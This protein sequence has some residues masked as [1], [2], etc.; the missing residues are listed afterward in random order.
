MDVP[1]CFLLILYIQ[2]VSISSISI[3]TTLPRPGTITPEGSNLTISCSS[4]VPWFFC[5]FNSPMGDKQCA[6]QESEVNSVCSS[7]TLL[8]LSG[9]SSTCS[10]DIA[11]VTRH[12]HGGWMC[13]LNEI[14]QF[15]SVKTIVKVE[16][17]VPAEVGWKTDTQEDI[18]HLTE[19]EE[20]EI[21]CLATDGYPAMD[22]MWS[23]YRT[24]KKRS[25]VRNAREYLGSIE[26]GNKYPDES[27]DSSITNRTGKATYSLTHGSHLYSG[28]QSLL[29]RANMSD[30][31]TTILCRVQQSTAD[32]SVLYTS[33]V[34]LQLHV[35]Q[36]IMSQTTAI[37]E[38]IGIIS[39]IILAI[40]FIILIFILIAFLLTR[41]RKLDKKY[42]SV[43]NKDE[44]LTP[45]W[46]PGKVSCMEVSS[47]R[48][49][50]NDYHENGDV[51]GQSA[52]TRYKI[53]PTHITQHQKGHYCPCPQIPTIPDHLLDLSLESHSGDSCTDNSITHSVAGATLSRPT[54]RTTKTISDTSDSSRSSVALD[55]SMLREYPV[56][57]YIS[58]HSDISNHVRGANGHVYSPDVTNNSD[59]IFSDPGDITTSCDNSDSFSR[60]HET[61]FGDSLSDIPRTVIH[62]PSVQYNLPVRFPGTDNN[63]FDCEL[64]CFITVEE[65]RRRQIERQSPTLKYL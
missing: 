2:A 61:H 55:K 39:G 34:Q 9:E 27:S 59:K 56:E 54:T 49:F 44:L 15:D 26:Q 52:S 1:S 23:S 35:E 50:A 12:M 43:P 64:G 21:V 13:L 37:E 38:N 63:I 17:G 19:G 47:A 57:S 41:R 25:L 10:L 5:L 33:T 36:L 20:K 7:D 46:V 51:Q 42:S 8:S 32:G 45:I 14:S 48:Q 24:E 11:R 31:G 3:V 16:V 22:F 18:L 40:I 65:Y 60:L 29:Y 6:I 4:S 62:S 53:V 58:F 28:S 30:N